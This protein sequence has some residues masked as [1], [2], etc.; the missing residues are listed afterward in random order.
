MV[1]IIKPFV[2]LT[3]VVSAFVDDALI[4]EPAFD[5]N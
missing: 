2:I 3:H 5:F 1:L 4:N